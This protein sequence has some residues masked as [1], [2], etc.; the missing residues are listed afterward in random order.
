MITAAGCTPA[1]YRIWLALIVLGGLA[2]RFIHFSLTLGSDDQVWVTVAREIS[3]H[4][5]QTD[6]PVYYTRIVWSWLLGLWGRIGS[7][8]LEW[9]AVLMFGLSGL[10]T[11]FI[12]EGAR[13][14]FDPRTALIAAAAY[15]IH[16]L[17]VTFDT[18]TLPDG[19]AVCVLS[20][21]T[22]RF[23]HYLRTPQARQLL[24]PGILIGLL[25][26]VKNYFM[27][28]SIPCAATILILPL[29]LRT[30]ITHAG[31]LAGISSASLVFALAL[32]SMSGVEATSHIVSAGN[33][34][35][36]IS[37]GSLTGQGIDDTRELV[38]TLIDRTRSIT[39]IFFSYGSVAGVL[40][41][42]GFALS[43]TRCRASPAHLFLAST[44]TV[45]L[46]FLMWMPVRLSPLLFTQ[47]HER[48]LTVILPALCIS[49]GAA[50]AE[51]W[52]A[53]ATRTL[54]TAAACSLIAVV[55]YSLWIPSGLHDQYG[56]LEMRGVARVVADAPE[57]GTTTLLMPAYLRRLVPDS[58]RDRG[59]Q[60]RFVDLE[61]PAG[62]TAAL[63]GIA[64]SANT[65]MYVVRTPYRTLTERLR[66][67]DYSN[68][69]AAGP[70][71]ALMN[72]ATSHG[73]VISEVRVPYDTLRV[74]LARA[75]IATRGQLVGWVIT[76]PAP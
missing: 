59:V 53:F 25:F 36:Y 27:L 34:V 20:A 29:P 66:T 43:V 15:A 48:Y 6:E 22:W 63:E 47:L 69:L 7:F 75:G 56:R 35:N 46:M 62:V 71:A 50:V 42:F 52:Q 64:A 3:T 45:F 58:Y 51:A 28:I 55:G 74:W 73:F 2:V 61:S 12:A 30:R 65:A 72:E 16:P 21:C 11:L 57:R 49:T 8:S 4:A 10:T 19:L 60:L 23:L 67:G 24:V 37:Q 40:T 14:A 70:Y 5:P 33:Y 1:T 26:G 54:R 41:L 18:F 31:L 17:A 38:T 9:T 13:S 44:V 76:R 32:G 68:D 39:V